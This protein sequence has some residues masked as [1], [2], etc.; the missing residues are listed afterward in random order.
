MYYLI[1]FVGVVLILLRNNNILFN[2]FSIIL[3]LLSFFRFGVGADYFSY[4]YI[5]QNLSSN[6]IQEITNS[7][8]H[9]EVLF[10]VIGSVFKSLNLSYQVFI[11]FFA[12]I[13]LYFI[14][15]LIKA[16]SDKTI[17]SL[18]IFYS[19]FYFV[20][21]F[22]GI[23]QGLTIAI[24]TYYLLEA[25]EDRKTIKFTFIVIIL[26]FIHSASL[27]LL[28]IYLLAN[29]DWTR[30]KLIITT[31]FS[32][33]CSILPIENILRLFQ[34]IPLIQRIVFYMDGSYSPLRILDFQSLIRILL[35]GFVLVFYNSYIKY[36]TKARNL[37]VTYII[38]LNLYFILKFSE[39]T[40]SRVSIYG[41]LLAIILLPNIYL[42]FKRD[43]DRFIY[44]LL[45]IIICFF[46]FNKELDAMVE[47]SGLMSY[48]TN[49]VPYTHVFNKFEGYSFDNRFIN[50]INLN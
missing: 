4:Q 8:L 41:Y 28:P 49:Y 5:Y 27:I 22:S 39:L 33:V 6:P 15:K 2:I 26:S 10:R 37:M 31:I 35:I 20:W 50:F 45:L 11:G 18:F 16:Y 1:F 3:L 47:S 19:F 46:Y 7:T 17:W 14:L 13:T 43:I 24:G 42:T 44:K 48:E 40:A 12:T 32:I 38:S 30:N 21:I 34:S 25:L 29:I 23:R 9:G 36:G